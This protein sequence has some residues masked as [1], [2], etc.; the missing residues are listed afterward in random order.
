M[1]I[2]NVYGPTQSIEKLAVWNK[3]NTFINSKPNETFIIGGD[4][5]VVLRK[6]EKHEVTQ[7]LEPW[8]ISKTRSKRTPSLISS[9]RMEYI[10]GIIE[11]KDCVT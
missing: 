2:I 11:E 9:P 1:I 8:K 7:L 5:K 4:F 3:I 6:K 10:H